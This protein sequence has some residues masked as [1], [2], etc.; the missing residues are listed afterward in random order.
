MNTTSTWRRRA[1]ALGIALAMTASACGDDDTSSTAATTA[2]PTAASSA[3]STTAGSSPSSASPTTPA[4]TTPA[5]DTFPVT[6]EHAFGSTTVESEPKKVVTV[7]FTDHD[8][9]LGLGV[10]PVGLRNWYGD[11]PRGVW[12]WAEELLGDAKP[13]V[14]P[15]GDLNFE[16][17]AALQPDLIL[18][19][20]I[21]LE[22]GDY[23]R[24][25]AI[26]PTIAQSGDHAPFGTPWQEMT[27]TAGKALGRRAEAE[28][29]ITKVT[30]RFAS[31]RDAHPE[32]DGI[33]LAYAGVYGEGNFYVETEG[34]T[35]VQVLLD[36][37][38]EVPAELEALGTDKFYHDLSPE[39]LDLLDQQIVLWEPADLSQL[40][41]VKENP[42]YTT[43]QVAKDGREVFL[44]DPLVAGAMAHSS[45]LS[46]PYVLDHIVPELASAV[47]KVQK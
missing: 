25:S 18:G 23:D 26:A 16:Q 4:P 19:L 44:T 17:I 15:S 27:R 29:A 36:L 9:V 34:S 35:R 14:L 13:T 8:T 46:L 6:I 40:P 2:A 21:G 39:R 1:V 10:V 20:Y 41:A 42:L 28:A 33:E 32:F 38:F 22:Q 37:G 45:V 47:A 5:A 43:L 7:G 31:E 30:D 3:S 24:L 12:P 11:H